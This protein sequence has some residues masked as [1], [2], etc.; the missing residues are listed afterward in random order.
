M[1]NFV[2]LIGQPGENGVPVPK[3]VV[4]DSKLVRGNAFAKHTTARN[5]WPGTR[6]GVSRNCVKE[7]IQRAGLATTNH[8][9]LMVS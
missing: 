2:Q 8:A 3:H 7:M 1:L 5:H 9:A 6:N 4:L